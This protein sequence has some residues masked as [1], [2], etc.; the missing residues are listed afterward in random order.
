[1]SKRA[2]YI[3]MLQILLRQSGGLLDITKL[4]APN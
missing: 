1:V 4:A 2:G 3:S